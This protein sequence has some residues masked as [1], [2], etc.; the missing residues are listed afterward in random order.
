MYKQP[1]PF[2]SCVLSF[3]LFSMAWSPDGR[4]LAAAGKDHVIRI[5]NPRDSTRPVSE[6][7]GPEGSRGARVVW[8]DNE[9]IVITGFTRCV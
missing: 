4:Q 3:Q 7:A 6:G 5:Y 2:L 9:H 8:L 1:L